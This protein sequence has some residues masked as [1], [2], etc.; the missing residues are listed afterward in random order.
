MPLRRRGSLGEIALRDVDFAYGRGNPVFRSAM[1]VSKRQNTALIGGS[2]SGKS[3]VAKLLL[4]FYDPTAGA[5]EID[6]IDIRSYTLNSIREQVAVV[7][8]ESVLFATSIRDNI[9]YGKLDAT[10]EEVFEAAQAAGPTTS[11]ANCP[12]DMTR[13][14]ASAAEPSRAGSASASPLRAPSCA[15]RRS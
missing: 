2:G 15:T 11:S 3:T 10:D 13:S 5:V 1:L 6:G 9:A 7:L 4:R 8:Q 12:M 14:S